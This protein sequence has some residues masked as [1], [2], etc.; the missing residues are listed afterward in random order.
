[1]IQ[2]LTTVAL[3]QHVVDTK[4]LLW[5]SLAAELGVRGGGLG[6]SLVGVLG[7]EE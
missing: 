3:G 4:L 6:R 2:L 5:R 1:M 7:M